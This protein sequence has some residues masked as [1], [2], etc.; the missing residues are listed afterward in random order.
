ME[1]S[2]IFYFLNQGVKKVREL[3]ACCHSAHVFV[4]MQIYVLGQM[5]PT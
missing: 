3:L 2:F 1:S 5:K 4:D